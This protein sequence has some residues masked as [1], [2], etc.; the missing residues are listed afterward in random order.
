[1]H[2]IILLILSIVIV[3]GSSFS[4]VI[5]DDGDCN[6]W[7]LIYYNSNDGETIEGDIS[8]LIN[9]VENGK[10]VRV[11]VDQG[12]I[13]FAT[14]AEYL[15]VFHDVVYAQNNG[16]VS[17]GPTG[18]K[19]NFINDSYYWMFLVNSKGERDMIRW[20]VGEHKM[21][22]RNKESVSVKWFIKD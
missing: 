10:Q 1:M 11:V 3:S 13:T 22:G 4:K 5:K 6:N 2:K 8:D 20:S 7:K 9:A 16:Q 18:N 15:W 12:S 21:V 17:V 19:L 14:D